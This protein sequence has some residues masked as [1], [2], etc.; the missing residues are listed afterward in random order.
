M[1]LSVDPL[2]IYIYIC[3]EGDEDLILRAQNYIKT[4]TEK[5]KRITLLLNI[6]LGKIYY[7]HEFYRISRLFNCNDC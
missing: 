6:R 3:K 7:E 4:E 1:K 5:N 2:C